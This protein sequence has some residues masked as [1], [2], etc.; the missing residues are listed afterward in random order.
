[1][2]FFASFHDY[3]ELNFTNFYYRFFFPPRVLPSLDFT[4]YTKCLKEMKKLHLK[5]TLM[6]TNNER[7]DGMNANILNSIMSI[8]YH[9][10]DVASHVSKN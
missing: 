2:H 6:L 5:G 8:C 9:L 1:M 10:T 7:H 4:V 3:L